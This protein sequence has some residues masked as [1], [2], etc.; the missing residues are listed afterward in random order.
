MKKLWII[1]YNCDGCLGYAESRE[2]A[3]RWLVRS[4]WLKLDD[5]KPFLGL[6]KKGNTMKNQ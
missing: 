1:S 4:G 2:D 6:I 3:I 5:E